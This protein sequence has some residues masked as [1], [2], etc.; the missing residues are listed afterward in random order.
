MSQIYDSLIESINKVKLIENNPPKEINKITS[1]ILSNKHYFVMDSFFAVFPIYYTMTTE[2]KQMTEADRFDLEA[3]AQKYISECRYYSHHEEMPKR[4]LNISSSEKDNLK[5]LI[6]QMEHSKTHRK[7]IGCWSKDL[8][9][10][11]SKRKRMV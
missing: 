8:I 3:I 11:K 5:N 10:F 9:H 1:F 7:N 6:I 2:T 4:V